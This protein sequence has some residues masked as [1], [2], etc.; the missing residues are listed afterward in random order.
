[1]DKSKQI[2]IGVDIGGTF[3]DVILVDERT[4]SVYSAKVLTTP[5]RP[6]QAVLAAV[7][8]V[9]EQGKSQH[10]DVRTIVHGTTLATNAIIERKGARTA[11]LC[12]QGF[13]DALETGTELRYDLHD[14][15][16]EF[17]QPLVM[18]DLRISIA[19]RVRFDGDV[20]TP[21][22]EAEV[23]NAL[24]ALA[25][26]DIEA[27]AVC[28]LHAYANP[29]NE[30]AAGRAIHA[31]RPDL[32]ISLSSRVL[33]EIG[34][35]G[36]VSTTVANAYVQPLMSRYLAEL[37]EALEERGSRGAFFVMSSSG[38]TLS[39]DL[40]RQFPVRLVE[41]GP[42]AGVSIATHFARR[43]GKPNVL[44]FDM[45]GT[46]AKISLI[47]GGQPTRTTE[48]E[49]ARVRRFQ[50]GSG[51]LLK[52]PAVDLIEIGAG[53][54]SIARVDAL[55]LLGVGPDSAGS[56]PG[57]A[58]YGAG[59]TS[60]TV[61]DADLVL[62]YLNADF[63]LGGKMR[64]HR[65]RA[66]ATIEQNVGTPL[67]LGTVDAARSI[68]EVVNDNMANAASVYAAEQGIDL[69]DFT[70]LAFGGAAPAHVCDV[71][72]RL[73]IRDVRIPVG[74]GVLSALG[75]LAS[76]VSFDFVFGYMRELKEVDWASVNVRFAALEKEGRQ[77]LRE[78]GIRDGVTTRYSADMRYLSQRYEVNVPLPAGKLGPDILDR[79]HDAFYTA[80]RQHYGRDIREVPVE[81]V[82]WRLTVSGPSPQLAVTWGG[83]PDAAVIEKGRRPVVFAGATA[84]VDCPVYERAR[85]AP[86]ASLPGPAIIEDIES[87]TV[88]PPGGRLDVDDLRMLVISL[89]G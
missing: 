18:R 78:A 83:S 81:T 84:A 10:G 59:G 49:V 42:A 43:L 44:A 19:E 12:T 41:S 35:Y 70:M 39:L 57:P 27:V 87:T 37:S 8:Q 22:D 86:G 55:G 45:G 48:L 7:A 61:T 16:I 89:K 77:H 73:G 13:R 67:G 6:A 62:G 3:T 17:P 50:K 15:F 26:E 24:R 52:A 64:L 75:C 74:A 53:G 1:M 40:A 14:L 46:T 66:S 9:L 58:C 85:L 25:G 54:G 68:Y 4:D 80:Y 82:S 36:R 28:F 38:G 21:L 56:D 34:E 5:E 11:L 51:L 20:L 30:E 33:P 60:A 63:F 2:A 72:K 47:T 76:P 65:E 32:A 88:V 29:A 79:L 71:A 23:R 69:R 31:E